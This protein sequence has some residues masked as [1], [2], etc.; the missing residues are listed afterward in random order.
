MR[1]PAFDGPTCRYHRLSDYLP[2][3]HPLPA[4]LRAVAAK[5]VHFDRFEI[6]NGNQVDQ[7]IGHWS[8]LDVLVISS[9]EANGSAL[10]RRPMNYSAP[11]RESGGNDREIS[12]LRQSRATE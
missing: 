8:A 5:H 6:E 3:K 1:Q 2:A 7:A 4:R 12:A 9:E 10:S 11:I